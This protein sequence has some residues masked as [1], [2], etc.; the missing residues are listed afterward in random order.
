MNVALPGAK[1]APSPTDQTVMASVGP[2]AQGKIAPPHDWTSMPRWVLYQ[3]PSFLGSCALMNTPPMPVTRFICP[4]EDANPNQVYIGIGKGVLVHLFRGFCC[5]RRP[6]RPHHRQAH[7]A[8]RR[9]HG[10]DAGGTRPRPRLGPDPQGPGL[11]G[12]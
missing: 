10:H 11:P 9:G 5:I 7:D 3:A 1:L 8:P 2:S 6:G 4:S 12:A